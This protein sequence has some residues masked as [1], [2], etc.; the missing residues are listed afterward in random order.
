MCITFSLNIVQNFIVS[1]YF[2]QS[3]TKGTGDD[4]DNDDHE[5]DRIIDL[6]N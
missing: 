4:D 6:V 1:Y 5:G 2:H 3:V